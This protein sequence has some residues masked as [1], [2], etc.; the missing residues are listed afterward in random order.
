M[1]LSLCRF[2][3]IFFNWTFFENDRLIGRGDFSYKSFH[4]AALL[5]IEKSDG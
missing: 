4:A 1:K 3:Y 2:A 5:R